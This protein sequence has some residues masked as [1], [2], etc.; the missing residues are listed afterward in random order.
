MSP[1]GEKKKP[2]PSYLEGG[3][4]YRVRHLLTSYVTRWGIDAIMSA[5]YRCLA[6]CW[7]LHDRVSHTAEWLTVIRVDGMYLS[8]WIRTEWIRC[9]HDP[10]G[11]S[12]V[13]LKLI[14]RCPWVGRIGQTYD[15]T[16]GLYPRH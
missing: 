14:M 16:R 7:Y 3:G 4:L 10:V 9:C 6:D 12:L 5:H 13:V 11:I 15:P 2:P 1:Q 8:E